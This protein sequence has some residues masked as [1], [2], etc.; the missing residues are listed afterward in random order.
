M[1]LMGHHAMPEVTHIFNSLTCELWDTMSCQR[2]P[3]LIP[4]EA[5]D[6]PRGYN[7]FNHVPLPTYLAWL[8]PFYYNARY[9]FIH[10]K[11]NFACGEDLNKKTY[12]KSQTNQQPWK[13][14]ATAIL[15]SSSH[16]SKNWNNCSLK[17]CISEHG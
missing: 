3:T 15:I 4:R 13:Y 7:H 12:S 11:T 6:F 10:I 9:V 17:N 8:K 14:R 5:E 1:W 16:E 2:S